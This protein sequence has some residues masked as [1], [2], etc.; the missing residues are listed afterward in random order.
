MKFGKLNIDLIVVSLLDLMLALG[1][2][3]ES[4]RDLERAPLV[5]EKHQHAISVEHVPAAE[6]HAGLLAELTGVADGAQLRVVMAMLVAVVAVFTE[7][8]ILINLFFFV[9]IDPNNWNE[10][11]E[12]TLGASTR[13][14][15]KNF[16]TLLSVDT[17][18]V[19][20]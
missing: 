12:G 19:Y 13:C 1:A 9:N 14:V 16:L 8:H 5:L 17:V 6:L 15:I 3:H 10:L 20:R 4:E 11:R 18:S 2:G 7:L